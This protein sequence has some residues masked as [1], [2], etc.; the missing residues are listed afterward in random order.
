MRTNTSIRKY[1]GALLPLTVGAAIMAAGALGVV[2]IVARH[3][4][5]KHIAMV[6]S[7]AGFGG[8]IPANRTPRPVSND[9]LA[10]ARSAYYAGHW[11]DAE[12]I[13]GAV[14]ASLSGSSDP[15]AARRVAYGEQIEAWSAARRGDLA[16]A[17]ERFATLRDTAASLPDHGAMKVKLGETPL[18]TLE[19]EG[20]FQHA[21]CTSALDGA[22]GKSAAEAEYRGFLTQY[23]RS[24][25]IHATVKRL[26]HMHGGDL[27]KSDEALWTADMNLQKREDKAER[28]EE[29]LCGPQCLAELLRRGGK[30]V[31]VHALANEMH[32]TDEGT[33]AASMVK[34]AAKH[35]LVLSGLAVT[36]RGLEKQALPAIALVSP[37]HYVIVE[38]ITALTVTAWDPGPVKCGDHSFSRAKW[39]KLFMG[40]VLARSPDAGNAGVSPASRH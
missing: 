3:R 38:R 24:I 31:D 28:R 9:P 8:Y 2:G 15:T 4:S 10:A 35:G 33:T 5:V 30:S 27:P 23:P 36:E 19:E 6:Y 37:G 13:A 25:L 20:S 11:T 39:A 1:G 29:S 14:C 17:R 40:A 18:P 22:R 34:S 12:Q 16:T 26:A 32:T 21:V 7:P